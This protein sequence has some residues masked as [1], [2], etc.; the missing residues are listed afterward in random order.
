MAP[1]HDMKASR[2]TYE[3][4]IGLFK[5]G[6]VAVAIIAALVVFLLTH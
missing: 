6:S 5:Y 3:G 2:Q 4:F 1:V